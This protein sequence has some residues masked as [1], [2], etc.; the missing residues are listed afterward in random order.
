[1]ASAFVSEAAV[2]TAFLEAMKYKYGQGRDWTV[3]PE[4]ADW[5]LLLVHRDGYQLGIEA[6]LKLNPKVV[7]QALNGQHNVWGGADGPDYRAV[8]V[9]N[10]GLQQHMRGIC[11]AIGLGVIT[12]R[13]NAHQ[14]SQW[15]NLPDEKDHHSRAWSNWCPSVRCKL[16]DYVPD[17]Q[18]GIAAPIQLTDWKV[19]AIRLMLVLERRGYVTRADMKAIGISPTRWT[20]AFYGYLDRTED[21]RFV[22]NERT[23]D[24]QAQHPEVWIKIKDEMPQWTVAMNISFEEQGDLL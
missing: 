10:D 5:D 15:L 1:M 19:K 24:L 14:G 13:P 23:P 11:D 17:V 8:L 7:A 9:P 20:D 12:I 18:A 21:R 22:R 2:V 3:Y 6:K 4:T 16:P